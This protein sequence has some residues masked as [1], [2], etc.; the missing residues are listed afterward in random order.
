MYESE[1]TGGIKSISG[2]KKAEMLEHVQNFRLI[3]AFF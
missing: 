3:A 2:G 1:I